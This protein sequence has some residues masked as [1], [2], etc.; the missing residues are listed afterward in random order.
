MK[1][2]SLLKTVVL[3]WLFVGTTDLASAYLTV[4]IRSG[5]F[6]DN[7]LNYIAGGAMGIQPAMAGGNWAALLGLCFHYFIALSFTVLFFWL[8]PRLKFLGYNKYLVGMLYA[9]FVNL[10]MGQVILRLSRL[11]VGPFNLAR[12]VVDWMSFGIVF[13]IPLVYNVYAYYRPAPSKTA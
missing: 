4:W 5:K 6:A 7:M 11:P 1:S 8:F 10:V 2:N 12:A 9:V 3:T 13:G